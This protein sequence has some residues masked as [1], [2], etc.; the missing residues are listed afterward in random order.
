VNKNGNPSIFYHG[1]SVDFDEFKVGKTGGIFFAKE[2]KDAERFASGDLKRSEEGSPNVMPVYLKVEKPFIFNVTKDEK[3]V[4][5]F[6]YEYFKRATWINKKS[7]KEILKD[8]W[9]KFEQNMMSFGIISKESREF[10]I[11]RGY[12]A[13]VVKSDSGAD[14][15]AV[16]YPNQIKSAIGN[17]GKFSNSSNKITEKGK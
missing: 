1:T 16:F 3:M 2:V 17:T 10:L 12:D 9:N 11:K 14:Q 6:F 5:D 13:I 8:K 15:Y 4:D 7:Q